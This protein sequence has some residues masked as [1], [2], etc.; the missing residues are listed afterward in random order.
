MQ[1]G[2]IVINVANNV[3]YTVLE[4]K[5]KTAV[6]ER[7]HVIYVMARSDLEVKRE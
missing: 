5:K 3:E 7:D 6:V 2:D 1:E 4:V